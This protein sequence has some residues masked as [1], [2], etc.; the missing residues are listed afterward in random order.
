MNALDLVLVLLIA[1]A[2]VSG[3]RRGALLQVLSYGGLLAGLA[4]GAVL[5]P[6]LAS[7]ASDAGVQ[8]GV[9]AGALLV[10]AGIGDAAGWLIGSRVRA[11]AHRTGF[12]P[13]DAAGGSLVSVVAVLLAIWFVALNLVN[14]PFPPLAREIRRSAVVRALGTAL[15]QPPSLLGEVRRFLDRFGFPE[16]FVGLPPAPA[17]PVEGPTQAEARRAFETAASS[18]VRIVGQAC[19]EVQEGTGFVVAPSYVLTN[20][21]VVA[22]V[23]DPEVQEPDGGSQPAVTVLYDP[24]IDLAVLRV[25]DTP[26]PA[27]ELLG[28]DVSRGATGAVLGYPQG[29]ELTGGRAAVRRAIPATGRD[30]YGRGTV[31]RD[32]YELQAVVRP[33]NSGGPFVLLDGDVAGVVFAASTTDAGVG[34]AIASTEVLPEVTR[35]VGRTAEV[36]TGACVR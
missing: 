2:A 6:F 3:F 25:E 30:I 4:A 23:D 10:V 19:G 27:L 36:P 26:G 33:G 1:L 31:D 12:R 35:A 15:P 22:G 7:L 29:G 18:T 21:H 11:A 24:R 5:A 17:G 32:V 34:Y 28:A 13:A 8:A 20:A 9:A 16:V 14:G